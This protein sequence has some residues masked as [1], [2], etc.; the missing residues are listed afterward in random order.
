MARGHARRR[1]GARGRRGG[2]GRDPGG[3]GGGDRRAV[4]GRAVRL[5]RDR[6]SAGGRSAIPPSR[7]SGAPRGGRRG[8][9]AVRPPRRDEPG[10][11]RHRGDAR[12]A[13][14]AEADRGRARRRRR[15]LRRARAASTARRST[16]GADAAPAG[17][18]DDVRAAGGRLARGRARRAAGCWIEFVPVAA[19]R[20][21]RD[22]RGARRRGLEVARLF[23]DEL[24]LAEPPRPVARGADADR[25]A[26]R[27]ARARGRRARE[28]RHSTSSCSPDRG[29]RGARARRGRLVDDAAEAQPGRRDA[30]PGLRRCRCTATPRCCAAAQAGEL[31]RAAGAWQ[32]EWDALSGALALTGGAAAAIRSAVDGLEVDAGRMRANI[33]PDALAEAARFGVDARESRGLPRRRRDAGRPRARR[34][35][36]SKGGRR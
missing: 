20:R 6:C 2:R 7:S 18:A 8:R 17:G 13:P 16:V 12:R 33:P 24:G 5:G 31:E 35:T 1:G 34:A 11:R 9:G 3:R 21:R 15:G 36:R 19:R 10:H 30:R 25:A 14:R 26:R 4:P 29:R 22:A 27:R 23:A 28:D 32:A